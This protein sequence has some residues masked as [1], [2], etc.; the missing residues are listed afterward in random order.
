MTTMNRRHL[1]KVAAALAAIA[2]GALPSEALAVAPNIPDAVHLS[3]M[4]FADQM[5][6]DTT[7]RL[8][9]ELAM[10]VAPEWSA[11][12]EQTKCAMARLLDPR[13][14]LPFDHPF[15]TMDEAAISFVW[16]AYCDGVQH[17]AAFEHVRS[18]R[19]GPRRVCRQ[20]D[21][22]GLIDAQGRWWYRGEAFGC[23]SCGGNGLT[24][25]VGAR[26]PV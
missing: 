14:E 1:M 7:D 12:Y 25:A 21:G 9:G 18:A 10:F 26:S 23:P 20:C 3:P 22:R 6:R 16:E 11:K 8:D 19:I 17:G 15:T 2:P 4:A 13:G 24:D 5:R